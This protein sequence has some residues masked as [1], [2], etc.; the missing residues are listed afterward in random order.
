MSNAPRTTVIRSSGS[1]VPPQVVTN[2]MISR[3]M[4]TTDEWIVPRTGIRE[5]RFFAPR[6][7]PAQPAA[8]PPRRAP[9]KAGL[10]PPPSR[11]LLFPAV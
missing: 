5:R 7:G 8:H 10:P 1:Y 4:D 2:E 11:P 9:E 3:I 6:D